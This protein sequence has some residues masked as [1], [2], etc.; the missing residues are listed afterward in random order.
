MSLFY[1][2]YVEVLALLIFPIEELHVLSIDKKE[3]IISLT[4]YMS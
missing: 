2:F 3:K 4:F 1:G